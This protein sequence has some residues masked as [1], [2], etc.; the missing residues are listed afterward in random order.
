MLKPP[1][2]ARS[3]RICAPRSAC[4]SAFT[5][6]SRLALDI[7]LPTLCVACR[8][9]VDGEGVCP[10]CWSKLSFI[11]RPYCPRLGIPFVYDPGPDM[12]SMEAIASPPAYRA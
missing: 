11:E 4:R 9:P 5:H 6:A 2:R 1:C 10:E 7:A 12:L 3:T 8:E